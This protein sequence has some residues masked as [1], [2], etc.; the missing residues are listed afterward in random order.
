MTTTTTFMM[1]PRDRNDSAEFF[2]NEKK[3]IP[4]KK[5]SFCSDVYV[6][7]VLH[8]KDYTRE[9]RKKCWYPKK[10]LNR[11]KKELHYNT[12]QYMMMNSREDTNFCF[13]GLENRF[14]EE[15]F[16]R[17][18]IRTESQRLILEKQQE[19]RNRHYVGESDETLP[20]NYIL[21]SRFCSMKAYSMG[22]RDEREARKIPTFTRF[23]I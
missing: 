20:S 7:K 19:L 15:A 2:V 10:K 5:V 8:H 17:R 22:V 6:C 4:R 21:L 11:M 16:E 1:A 23:E 14:G 12:V 3:K 13:R 9:E 18:A